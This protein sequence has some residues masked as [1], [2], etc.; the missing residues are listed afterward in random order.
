MERLLRKSRLA[1][2][3][4]LNWPAGIL[5]PNCSLSWHCI[6]MRIAHADTLPPVQTRGDVLVTGIKRRA[7]AI[8]AEAQYPLTLEFAASRDKPVAA[9]P[10]PYVSDALVDIRDAHGRDVLSARSE[11]PLVL[12]RL[13]AGSY[14]IEAEWNG[15]RKKRTIALAENKRQHVYSI[16]P[17]PNK[18]RG[19]P[20]PYLEHLHERRRARRVAARSPGIMCTKLR[21]KL[22]GG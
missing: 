19:A 12:I 22:Q 1:F 5:A 13:P 9:A 10:A 20:R 4:S 2:A 17:A 7:D 6:G 3:P 21:R 14:T 18:S 15:V 16:S 11:G 8:A